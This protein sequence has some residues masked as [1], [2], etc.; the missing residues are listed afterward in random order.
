M[1]G[2]RQILLYAIAAYLAVFGILFLFAPRVAMRMTETTSSDA[3]LVL[4][5][6]Q[7]ALTFAAVA[8]MAAREKEPAGKLSLAVL[9]L[10]LGHVLV[11]GYLLAT[12]ARGFAQAGP[13]VI[14]NL[15]LAVLLFQ[16]RR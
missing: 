9:L 5:Y 10:L 8:F 11:F 12:G 2:K 1:T 7:Y 4:L 14:V 16:F 15:V 6:G 13:P 3:S